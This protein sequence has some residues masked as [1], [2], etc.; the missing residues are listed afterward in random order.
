MKINVIQYDGTEHHINCES[1]EFRTNQVS[2]WIRIKYQNDNEE[3]IHRI[4]T[5]KAE[6]E[7]KQNEN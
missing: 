1:F 2:N 7:E 5:I 4:A 6:R 3:I